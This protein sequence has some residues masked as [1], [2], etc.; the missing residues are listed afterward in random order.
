MAA[1]MTEPDLA[2]AAN[3]PFTAR[4]AARLFGVDASTVRHWD[5]KGW[6]HP[7]GVRGTS[8]LYAYAELADA[9]ARGRNSASLRD[10]RFGAHTA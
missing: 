4:E 8:K 9:D 6:I 2:A 5:A 7:V 1:A 3:V 10:V